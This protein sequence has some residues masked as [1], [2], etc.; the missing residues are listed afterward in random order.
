MAKQ[1]NKKLKKEQYALIRNVVIGGDL[2]KAG[3]KVSLTKEGYKYFKQQK[4]VK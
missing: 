1:E 4:Y 3:E 2:K